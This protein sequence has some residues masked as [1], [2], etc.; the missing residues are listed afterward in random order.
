M[1]FKLID[2]L[3]RSKF[4]SIHIWIFLISFLAYAFTAMDVMLISVLLRPIAREFNLTDIELGILG[5]SGYIGMFFGAITFGFIADRI[6]RKK[7][8][9]LALII[10]SVFTALCGI[11][12]NYESLLIIRA[13]AGIGLGGALP[14]PGV[15]VSEYPPARYRGRM[16]GLVETAWVWGVLLGLFLSLFVLPSWGWRYTFFVGIIPLILVPLVLLTL[17]E[18]IRFLEKKKRIQEAIDILKKYG[19]IGKD[20]EVRSEDILIREVKVNFKDLFRGEY[21]KRTVLLIVLWMA[22]VYTYH[23]IFLWLPKFYAD[24]FFSEEQAI[25]WTIIVTIAQIPGYYTAALSLDK[26]GRKII[27]G[28]YLVGASVGCVLLA[29]TSYSAFYVLIASII[30]A[31]F[32]LGAWSALYTYTPEMYPT[33]YRGTGSGTAASSGRIAGIVAPYLTGYFYT[34]GGLYLPFIAFFMVHL[35]AGIIVLILGIETKGKT[36]EELERKE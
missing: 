6:G 4:M 16:I 11:T 26:F 22:L 3:E 30:I 5:S 24:K 9:A 28:F 15:Y 7:T 21:F 23:G 35:V 27:L 17:P 36:L 25:L 31:F 14:I 2:F 10:Y 19:F 8:L 33:D 29:I 1:S 12:P 34:I 13:I 20:E 32:N 18:S